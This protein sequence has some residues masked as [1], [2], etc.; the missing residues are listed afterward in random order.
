MVFRHVWEIRRHLR[1]LPLLLRRLRLLTMV[2]LL[3][4]LSD[5]VRRFPI[6]PVLLP[7]GASTRLGCLAFLHLLPLLLK[8]MLLLKCRPCMLKQRAYPR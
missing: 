8:R 1:L 5:A 2:H 3:L 6:F 4:V 7:R